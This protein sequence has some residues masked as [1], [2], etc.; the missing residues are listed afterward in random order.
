MVD[1]SLNP[2]QSISRPNGSRNCSSQD[3]SIVVPSLLPVPLVH[4]S[5]SIVTPNQSSSQFI[6][7]QSYLSS[8]SPF[9]TSLNTSQFFNIGCHNVMGLNNQLKQNQIFHFFATHSYDIVGLSET[10]LANSSTSLHSI[11]TA[12]RSNPISNVLLHNTVS[13][14]RASTYTSWWSHH[15]TA[16]TS[17]GVGVLVSPRFSKYVGKIIKGKGRFIIVDFLFPNHKVKVFICYIPAQLSLE[18]YNIQKELIALMEKARREKF[19]VIIMGDLNV[20]YDDYLS[21]RLNTNFTVRSKKYGLVHYLTQNNY[22]DNCVRHLSGAVPTY[23]QFTSHSPMASRLDYI[24]Y[25]DPFLATH[26]LHTHLRDTQ[27]FYNSD[28]YLLT[29]SVLLHNLISLPTQAKV[30]QNSQQRIVFLTKHIALSQWELFSSK[31]DDHL[32]WFV[33]SRNLNPLS[34]DH[35]WHSLKSAMLNAAKDVL[36]KK[37]VRRS[38]HPTYPEHITLALSHMHTVSKINRR[39]SKAVHSTISPQLF[40]L[41][42]T[43]HGQ[44][45]D[46]LSLYKIE[47]SFTLSDSLSHFSSLTSLQSLLVQYRAIKKLLCERINFMLKEHSIVQIEVF[48]KDR[49]SNYLLEKKLFISSA[50]GRVKRFITLDK[51]IVRNSSTKVSQLITDPAAIQLAANDHFQN[52]VPIRSYSFD[53]L[54]EL[55]AIWQEQYQPLPQIDETVYADLMNPVTQEEWSTVIRTLPKQK[56]AGPSQLTYEMFAHLGPMCLTKTLHLLDLCLDYANIPAE[57]RE[58]T[59]FPIPKPVDWEFQLQNTGQSRY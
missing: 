44:L 28:H 13:S 30:K 32:L 14:S 38:A 16:P 58:A 8:Y 24:W 31:M 53:R 54:N 33:N 48:A 18:R 3:S 9:N 41:W 6:H 59:V 27:D 43:L 7:L 19:S 39:L 52:F 56:A 42:P 46:I 26:T 11:N 40:L 45:L 1:N 20:D 36:P 21:H 37:K 12:I 57:W 2:H 49:Y 55:P 23:T 5:S 10:K 15:P 35:Q 47:V 29:A 34:L 25:S 50:L 51:L 4:L 22:I 17:G